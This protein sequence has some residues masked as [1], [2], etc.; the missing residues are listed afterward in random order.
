MSLYIFKNRAFTITV[1]I[2]CSITKSSVS[3]KSS[4]SKQDNC[5]FDSHSE[6][7]INFNSSP[8]C[9][10][11]VIELRHSTHNDSKNRAEN[12]EFYKLVG[13][14]WSQIKSNHLN[15]KL[16][17]KKSSVSYKLKIYFPS[18]FQWHPQFCSALERLWE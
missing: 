11:R 14:D 9:T 5:E 2:W 6:K 10:K 13:D 17:L 7:L 3:H 15:T 18:K 8:F 16:H 1:L 4:I 12:A